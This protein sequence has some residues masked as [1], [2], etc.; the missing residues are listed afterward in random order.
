MKPPSR[1][2]LVA[3]AILG[4]SVALAGP[5]LFPQYRLDRLT[6]SLIYG[7]C[8]IGL[9]ILTGRTGQLSIGH[10]AFFGLGAYGVA[11]LL[12]RELAPLWL[13]LPLAGIL[14]GASGWLFGKPALRLSGFNLAIV[15]AALAIVF[16]LLVQRFAGLTG[17]HAGLAVPPQHA[18]WGLALS[19]VSW[20][21]MVTV[22]VTVLALV[23]GWLLT[24][25]RL[26]RALDA[27][28]LNEATAEANGV[29][30][31][32]FKQ[33]AFAASAAYAGVAGGLYAAAVGYIAPE[34]FGLLLNLT[35]L[36]AMLAGGS[37]YLSG[38]I[39]GGLLV[40]LVPE[41]AG[42]VSQALTQMTFGVVLIV[43]ITLAPRGLMGA[44][45]IDRL[46]KWIAGARPGKLADQAE[47]T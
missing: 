32:G 19:P 6:L 8:T 36:A 13:A 31:A 28:R 26:G 16:P 30:V 10:S 39:V 7:I 25:G 38:A 11:I 24:R 2:M 9:V 40:Q 42:E 43:V 41:L 45:V 18:P 21:Y 47:R 15:T 17:G 3:L 14:A 33:A 29:D 23:L 20:I 1:A 37:R 44:G 12:S 27:V 4:V 34:A 35:F 46:R 5:W 22:V